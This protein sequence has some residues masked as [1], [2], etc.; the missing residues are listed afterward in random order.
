VTLTAFHYSSLELEVMRVGFGVAFA[1]VLDEFKFFAMRGHYDHPVGIARWVDLRWFPK[2]RRVLDRAALIALM[3]YVVDLQTPWALL[4]LTLY[5][6]CHV[7]LR[8]SEGSINHG[9]HVVLAIA[10]TQLAAIAV[11]NAAAA[12][13][14][15]LGHWL[16]TSQADTMVWWTV[17]ALVALYFTSGLTKLLST[18]GRWIQRSPGLLVAATSRL[19]TAGAMANGGNQHIRVRVERYIGLL[20]GHPAATR[21]L[22]A[23]GLFVE[24]WSPLGLIG[25]NAMLAVGI[26][27]L[28]LHWANSRLLLLPFVVN[29]VLVFVYLVN[30][31]RL[32]S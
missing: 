19:E 32:W 16:A 13:G 27:L 5:L 9:N 6:L 12:W 1:F 21:V 11:W 3:A 26:A 8:C 28:A 15:D 18:G 7:T 25:E 4:Y 20:L 2:H 22:F 23:G 24:L 14:W 31:P 29:Q 30:L 17:Q 10:M